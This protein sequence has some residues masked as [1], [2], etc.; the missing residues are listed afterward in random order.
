MG[1]SETLQEWLGPRALA[2]R[3]QELWGRAAGAGTLWPG[4]KGPRPPGGE[5]APQGYHPQQ[6]W[7]VKSGISSLAKLLFIN[8]G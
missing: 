7:D 3:I 8:S 5:A 6:Q 1:A 4:V 2:K